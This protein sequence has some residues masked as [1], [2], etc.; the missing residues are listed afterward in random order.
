MDIERR[1][2]LTGSGVAALAAVGGLVLPG[3]AEA[4]ARPEPQEF[5]IGRSRRNRPIKAYLIGERDAFCSYV[6]QGQMH[7]DEPAGP[8]V[9]ANRLLK[10][11]P[12]RDVAF[13]V[14]PT[15]NPDGSHRGTRV[16]ANGV[17]LNRNFPSKTWRRQGKGTRYY[18]GPRPASEP[19][20]R[21]MVRFY[22]K[23]QPHTIISLHQPLAC[24]DY[25]GGDLDVTHWL[26]R[27]LY[28]RSAHLG[29]ST[30]GGYPG[31]MSSWFNKTYRK[32]T[33]V[34]VELPPTT[35]PDYRARVARV[36]VQ[37]AEHRCRQLQ[38]A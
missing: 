7:G 27:N 10:I 2:F 25:S 18:G 32:Q 14:V 8:L 23:I 12:I 4:A 28:L 34:T 3:V 30:G 29:S 37:H 6:V 26:A 15:I 35:D 36:L 17:D 24:V 20:T 31:T 1:E 11:A 21:S 16:N 33:C 5:V 22:S 9:A 38:K 13:W 19:E